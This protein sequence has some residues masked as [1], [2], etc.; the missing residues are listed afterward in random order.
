MSKKVLVVDDDT[1]IREALRKV[2]QVEGYEVA[3]AADGQEG[4]EQFQRVSP[5]LL[6]LDL[7]LPVKSGWDAFERLT[8]LNPLVPVIIITGQRNQAELAAQAGVGA[9]FEKPLD[10]P[11]LLQTMREL[12]AEPP[13]T[14]LKRLAGLHRFAGHAQPKPARE[15]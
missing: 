10:V 11:L 6:L 13:D 3:V 2:L 5:H 14:H 7:N 9:L 12:L 1:Q 15:D 4:I 8:S